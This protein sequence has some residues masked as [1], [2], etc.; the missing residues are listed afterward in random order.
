MD[1]VFND[2][3]E[4]MPVNVPNEGSLPG[5]SDS[6]VVETLGRCDA[7]RHPPEPMPALPV[8]LRGLVESLACY[9]QAAADT[10]WEGTA[11]DGI[12]TLASHPLV[13]SLD[14]ADAIYRDM[15]HAHRAYLPDR[16]LP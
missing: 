6:L 15:A 14:V 5:F 11:H 3:D 8:H 10:A 4:L 7:S 1:A 13:R 12:R 16:L 2:R 9:Q